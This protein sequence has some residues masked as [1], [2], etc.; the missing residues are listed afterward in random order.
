M[1]ECVWDGEGGGDKGVGHS[2]RGNQHI[3]FVDD[4]NN[5]IAF[6]L[7]YKEEHG[8]KTKQ[9]KTSKTFKT[10]ITMN[11]PKSRREYNSK[12]SR[13]ADFSVLVRQLSPL[14]QAE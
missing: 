1:S 5:D 11:L 10:A 2:C 3:F 7:S 8:R 14:R 4:V 6:S 12:K 13:P 9:N